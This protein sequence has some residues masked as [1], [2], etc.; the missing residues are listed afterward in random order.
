MKKFILPVITLTLLSL[1]LNSQVLLKGHKEENGKM[2]L[3]ESFTDL[4]FTQQFSH[5][6][7]STVVENSET[8][9]RLDMGE[10]MLVT[11]KRAEAELPVYSC[12]VE[13]PL[14]EDIE[15]EEKVLSS[16]ILELKDGIKI[17]P[18]QAS[19]SK[20]NEE[21]PFEM[22]REYYSRN[23][24]GNEVR[25]EI[26]V[27]GIMNGVRLAR[28]GIKPVRY[29]PAANKIEIA[30]EI[31]VKV[32]FVNPDYNGTLALRA[33]ANNSL[34]GFIGSRTINSKN[35]SASVSGSAVSRPYK[36]VIVSDPMFEEVLQPFIQWK[37]EQGFEI[38]ETYTDQT[39]S[40]TA[41]IKAYLQ[42][43]WDEAD[44]DNPSPDYLLI[45]GDTGQVPTF[46]GEHEIY[47][48][49]HVTDLY[50]A[51]Y[52]G[53][54]LPDLF[55]GRFSA[56][57]VTDM[58]AIVNK[59]IT[60]EKYQFA[61]QDK[62]YLNRILLVAG[63]ETSSP[64]PT[65]VNGQMNYVKNYFSD[66]DTSVYYNP[67][68]GDAG[69][70]SQI[71]NKLDEGQGFVN[72]SAHCDQYG[73]YIPEFLTSEVESMS[74]TGKYGFFV[75]NCCLSSK[76]DVGEC[77][78]EKLL[79]AD[80]KGAVAV[81]GGSNST[82]WNEDFYWSVGSKT[83]VLN[84]SYDANKL[85][86]YDRLF[87]THS[88][89]FGSWYT[90]AGQ[91]VQAGNLAVE[92]MNSELTNYYWEIYNCMGDPSLT[93]Y[94]GE[95]NMFEDNLPEM[96]PLGT[97]EF[98]LGN[99]P[100]YTYVGLSFNGVLRGASQADETGNVNIS[101][102][103]LGQ[104]GYLKVV[105]SNQFYAPLTDSI[106]ITQ[107]EDAYILVSD[108]EFIDCASM[109][110]ADSLEV[111]K[112]Y[113]INCKLKNL[114]IQTAENTRVEIEDTHGTELLTSS[115]QTGN[116][117]SGA[118]VE[119]DNTLKIRIVDGLANGSTL[120]VTLDINGT[121]YSDTKRIRKK[122]A[123]PM[124]DILDV[125]INETQ[126]GKSLTF[127]LSN[128][129]SVTSGEG[130]VRF[131]NESPSLIDISGESSKS[132]EALSPGQSVEVTFDLYVNNSTT[133][134][135]MRFTIMYSAGNYQI[136]K[137]YIVDM[138]NRMETFE[139]GSFTLEEWDLGSSYCWT[140]DTEEKYNG[141][142]SARSAQIGNSK[143]SALSITTNVLTNDSISFYYKVSSE[144][145]YDY[146]IFYIDDQVKIKASGTEA[147]WKRASFAVDR[148]EHT[149]RFEYSK[150]YSSSQGSDAAWIDDVKMPLS[151]NVTFDRT[152]E[153][154]N[155]LKI[156][157]NP[158][159][160][161]VQI[162]NLKGGED[163]MIFDL[164]GRI[165]YKTK[166][167][168]GSARINVNML[169][170]GSYYICVKDSLKVVTEKLMIAR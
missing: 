128:T 7:L 122:I 113:F 164:N 123:A 85:G 70:V 119:C 23:S 170:S 90:T 55:Y 93:P 160:D 40:T 82:Y 63:K 151:G 12:L 5:L 20:Q 121:D 2:N 36:M 137:N 44:E 61:Q 168:N 94:V 105:L 132:V 169:T 92:M 81:I 67:S 162:D 107:S 56:S 30:K 24:F 87:H 59:T 134:E 46:D 100:A 101:F 106:R 71:M 145:N 99:L 111:N 9:Y 102:E 97:A 98:S 158:A 15:I 25:T 48:S 143:V 115:M 155:G 79:R 144:K 39:G 156:Y 33:K 80:N 126:G 51:E 133:E 103:P 112:E 148:G 124:P 6:E 19:Q 72:Y 159:R 28:L 41:G 141:N 13:I 74:N 89:P 108:V 149:F 8:F 118:E 4:V 18:R 166:S 14:C 120:E 11:E 146:F 35:I 43:L 161:F 127:T 86:A 10:N 60:Y 136:T 117:A 62:E 53:D 76:F 104:E 42:S 83:P 153:E 68:S 45:C 50:Y 26:E 31:E 130:E 73:W 147:G 84:P 64:A 77:F 135:K 163:I 139:N 110:Q 91:M 32:H 49:G 114:G 17:L 150:D 131:V 34:A 125:S 37:T 142:Y 88:E 69:N 78:A 167:A 29:N 65:C 66:L 16:E 154:R 157:P 57:N 152:T 116:I 96:L 138:N 140:T 47:G 54:I 22:N 27:L 52:T 1:Q 3:K 109:Q 129:G 75:N 165:C 21:I 95:A 38:I 58:Q